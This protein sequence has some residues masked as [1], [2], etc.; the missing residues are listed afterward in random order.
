[1]GSRSF[2][3]LILKTIGLFF[4]RD[5]LEAF[6]HTLSAAIYAPQYA[7]SREAIVNI[8]ASLP[9]LILFALL[10]WLFIF[11]SEKIIDLLQLEKNESEMPVPV[12]MTRHSLL[13]TAVIISG[14]WLVVNEIPEFFRHATYYYQE[15][16]MYVRMTRPDISYLVMSVMKILVG[17]ILI[18]FNKVIVK[19]IEWGGN[20]RVAG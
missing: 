5:V 18:V 6:S 15:R 9:P 7:S 2:F 1:M 12:S 3:N 13:A 11:R 16:K 14:A 20:A 17:L 8:S 10:V 19:I 4:I